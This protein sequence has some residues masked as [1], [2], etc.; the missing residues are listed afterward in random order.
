MGINYS[1]K[2]V[3]NGLVLCL[4]AANSLSYPG[5]GTVWTDLS[6]NG[7]NGTLTNGPT[8]SSANRGS[9]VFDGSN[10]YANLG[11]PSSLDFGTGSLSISIWIK[12]IIGNIVKVIMSKGA[13]SGNGSSGWWFALDNRYNNN[14]EG[15]TF[16]VN[17]SS[18]NT[19][20]GAKGTIN[21]YTINQ[22]NNIVAVWDSSTKDIYI[23]INNILSQ[24]T[25]V[26]TGGSSLAGVTDTNN[27]N[28]NTIIAAYNNGSSSFINANMALISIY[29]RILTSSE[30]S[31][32][33][34][35][36]KGRF[37]L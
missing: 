32:N 31:Q 37:G 3:T 20:S 19:S 35:A 24:T 36:T 13:T 34:N 26:Q 9:I 12:P 22:W 2:I 6:G 17:S 1:P 27:A 4:D 18:I 8:Y 16:S 7:N 29:N 5:S 14:T 30:I 11:K 25:L 33:Y 23:Y 28:F 21:K 10:D 15:V